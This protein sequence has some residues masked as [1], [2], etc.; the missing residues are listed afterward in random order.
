MEPR[1]LK[2]L[3]LLRRCL[4]FFQWGIVFGLPTFAV[5]MLFRWAGAIPVDVNARGE[6]SHPFSFWIIIDPTTIFIACVLSSSASWLLLRGL[7]WLNPRYFRIYRWYQSSSML[8]DW[9]FMAFVIAFLYR[10]CIRLIE[11]RVLPLVEKA[12]TF[13]LFMSQ[14][15]PILLVGCLFALFLLYI[16]GLIQ[17]NAIL[18]ERGPGRMVAIT[19]YPATLLVV[20]LLIR[21][22]IVDYVLSTEN[23][24][25]N[26]IYLCL[27]VCATSIVMFGALTLLVQISAGRLPRFQ[28]PI[29]VKIAMV[30]PSEVGK[31][32]YMARAYKELENL[33][34]LSTIS[35]VP[36]E[37]SKQQ[38]NPISNM[39]E[40]ARAIPRRWP[41]GSVTCSNAPFQLRDALGTMMEFEWMDPPGGAFTYEELDPFDPKYDNFKEEYETF[42][43]HLAQADA[44]MMLFRADDL[45]RASDLG[46]YPH[47]SG[48]KK[49]VADLYDRMKA[50]NTPRSV[51]LCIVVTQCCKV[52][53]LDRLLFRGKLQDLV[54]LYKEYA[55]DNS[56]PSPPVK[57]YFTTAIITKGPNHDLPAWPTPLE[58]E[59]CVQS[60]AWLAARIMRSKVGLLDQARG[61]VT[62]PNSKFQQCITKI[63][64]AT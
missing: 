2:E 15:A 14:R 4:T 54:K 13:S 28:L 38:L 44:M 35:L 49:T 9:V 3:E 27:V 41:D 40:G 59:N 37:E 34:T 31:T 60:V 55:V 30:A 26:L 21:D 8:K 12:G 47:F 16:M 20:F 32:V 24:A 52:S 42:R 11:M 1:T 7:S 61:F 56:L 33:S 51:P 6:T 62:K 48:Y 25:S 58:S 17:Q 39:L 22:R 43:D 23:L 45:K 53:S 64:D 57:I 63:E 46:K 10:L 29:P 19:L 50:D 5:L 18:P 36:T